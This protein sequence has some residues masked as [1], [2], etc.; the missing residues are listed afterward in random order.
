MRRGA[1]ILSLILLT[2][3]SRATVLEEL[4]LDDLARRADSVVVGVIGSKSTIRHGDE[5]LT[6]TEVLVERTLLG[7][8]RASFLV[9]QLGGESDGFVTEI[10]GDA[11]LRTGRRMVLFTYV[12]PDGRR[13][14]VGMALGA[15]E[16]SGAA[17]TQL[18]EASIQ[19]SDGSLLPPRT[20]H[21]TLEEIL[22]VLARSSQK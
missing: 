6:E 8:T 21:T 4:T 1:T 2:S 19:R 11:R 3:T 18:I 7:P 12:H 5:L 13:Y 17:A 10:V 15:F 14:L 9:T 20:Q 22:R 16:L